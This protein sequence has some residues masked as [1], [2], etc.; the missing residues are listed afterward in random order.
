MTSRSLRAGS[1]SAAAVTGCGRHGTSWVRRHWIMTCTGTVI[2]ELNRWEW[3]PVKNKKNLRPSKSF[4]FFWKDFENFENFF[5][6][7]WEMQKFS[8]EF[9]NFKKF[10]KINFKNSKIFPK[11][12]RTKINFAKNFLEFW[13]LL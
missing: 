10:Q 11:K 9:L 7:V 4:E 6:K 8:K 1:S 2:C 13:K 12:L 5:K 3:I